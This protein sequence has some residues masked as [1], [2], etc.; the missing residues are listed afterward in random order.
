MAASTF[1]PQLSQTRITVT[2]AQLL[3]L[4]EQP[5]QLLSNP[6]VGLANVIVSLTASLEFNSVRYV[7]DGTGPGAQAA[8]IVYS[9]GYAPA[10]AAPG[11]N[12]NDL[13]ALITAGASAIETFGSVGQLP[14]SSIEGSA[15]WLINSMAQ[16]IDFTLGNSSLAINILYFIMQL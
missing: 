15:V 8:A 6:G 16:P 10:V 4:A 1:S 9:N 13:S 2:A 7:N 3:R 5:I 12:S 14:R 11:T